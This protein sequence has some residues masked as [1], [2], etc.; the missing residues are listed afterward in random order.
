MATTIDTNEYYKT[1]FNAGMPQGLSGQS[2]GTAKTTTPAVASPVAPIAPPTP[3]PIATPTSQVATPPRSTTVISNQNKL[4]QI[5]NIISTTKK[6]ADAYPLVGA[7]NSA[8]ID[9]SLAG[10]S[11][12][13]AQDNA[14]IRSLEEQRTQNDSATAR[15]VQAVKDQYATLRNQLERQTAG[16]Q[17]GVNTALM[18]GGV[19]GKGSSSQYAP[20]SSSGIIQSQI[21]YGV[22][23]IADLNA[24]EQ[25][26]IAQAQAAGDNKN[27]QLMDS[28]N[29]EIANIRNQKLETA[30]KLNDTIITQN[31]KLREQAMQADKENAIASMFSQGI[32]SPAA[33]IQQA[34]GM[35]IPL[36][37]KE[38]SEAIKNF[39][40]P[41]YSKDNI[42]GG[43][44]T[45]YFYIDPITGKQTDL[46]APKDPLAEML[47]TTDAAKL[48][49]PYGTT[50]RQALGLGV[51][52]DDVFTDKDKRKVETDYRKELNNLSVVKDYRNV[53]NNYNITNN[54]LPDALRDS[55]PKS[56][57]QSAIIIAFN[58]LLDPNS[59]VR[60][61]EYGRSLDGQSIMNKWKGK[62]EQVLDGS[63]GLAPDDIRAI[64]GVVDLAYES[65]L[66]R[67]VDEGMKYRS[68]AEEYGADPN[69][70]IT[71]SDNELD[72]IF[73]KY[74]KEDPNVTQLLYDL[75]SE[76]LSKTEILQVL[77]TPGFRAPQPKSNTSSGSNF[78]GLEQITP[79]LK[80]LR[81]GG[82][83]SMGGTPNFLGNGTP[84]PYLKTLGQ[85]TGYG[86]KYWD[87]GLDV[88][89]KV[90]DPVYSPVD[91]EVI[92]SKNAGGFGKQVKI[93]TPEG[94]EIWL[95]HLDSWNVKKGDKVRAGQLVGK[96]GKTGNVIPVG[97]GDGSHL[98]ITMKD[99]K[100]KYLTAKQVKEYLDKK[101]V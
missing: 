79:E 4:E 75:K 43:Q 80:S 63:T 3:T 69:K 97:G 90:G 30:S 5:P 64:K 57:A 40:M 66:D 28:I 84:K 9:P 32:T 94:N 24:K 8:Q 29:R 42:F 1:D 74:I 45:G 86:S 10:Y 58:K 7:T 2:F 61:G 89:L 13:T 27:F 18:M 85:I 93:R 95:S 15:A 11:G 83:T 96:G 39:Q 54:V 76:G 26:A 23:K 49:V 46:I 68:Y 44:D 56:P 82:D 35:G 31:A 16:Q 48:G 33:I 72:T 87:K 36:T 98:D 92:D 88:D 52:T 60:E 22:E 101:Q 41:K 25:S 37:S 59:V 81:V 6:F 71:F 53:A 70:V 73:A 12:M 20:I 17:A 38:V 34:A 47:S 100:G 91:G 51:K 67:Y 62:L 21:N 14:I 99:S 65:Y 50:K 77:G 55:N 19:S 78:P